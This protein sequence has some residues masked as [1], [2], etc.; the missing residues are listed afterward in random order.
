MRIQEAVG[1]YVKCCRVQYDLTLDQFASESRVFGSNWN[2]S[3][4]KKLEEGKM[5]M[6]LDN[7]L[8]LVKT[9]SSLTQ[10]ETSLSK[11][12]QG[13]GALDIGDSHFITRSD[14][15]KALDGKGYEI[16]QLQRSSRKDDS[17]VAFLSK[18]IMEQIPDIMKGVSSALVHNAA[19]RYSDNFLSHVPTL[20]EIRASEKL[21]VVPG[22]VA[23]LCLMK[24]GRFLDDETAARAGEGASP[25][26]RGRETRGV[27]EE[28]DLLLDDM[29]NS[30]SYRAM[31]VS[32]LG[33]AAKRGDTDDEQSEYEAEP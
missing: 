5:S 12:F 1:E 7:L 17:A 32:E 4:V 9:I 14:I 19:R 24:Y 3:S 23:A 13:G 29:M 18:A 26:K 11:V 22:A 16:R 27:L 6:T 21:N 28:L 31:H 15:C 10:T 30:D 2:Y 33:L 25:Q 20:S 8:I